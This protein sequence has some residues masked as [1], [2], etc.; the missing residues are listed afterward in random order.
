MRPARAL[1]V[2]LL[3]AL[4]A[5]GLADARPRREPPEERYK[6]LVV[7]AAVEDYKGRHER[8]IKWLRQAARIK[9]TAAV[10][11]DL[12]IA[13]LHLFMRERRAGNRRG[14]KQLDLAAQC[15][16]RCE[17]M[18]ARDKLL[19]LKRKALAGQRDVMRF[20]KLLR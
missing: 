18:A 11:C 2:L 9:D 5:S 12:G 17:T 6:R 1:I 8:A 10:Q 15:F 19:P 14:A 7:L 3:V 4:C 20:K 13:H 16:K